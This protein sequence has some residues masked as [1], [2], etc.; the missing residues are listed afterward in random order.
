[1]A[2]VNSKVH[3]LCIEA[4]DY[5]DCLVINNKKDAV[6]S[7]DEWAKSLTNANSQL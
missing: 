2:Q 4:K 6:L 5:A 7:K 1:M 3:K